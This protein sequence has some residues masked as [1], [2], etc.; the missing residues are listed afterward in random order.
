[1][2]CGGMMEKMKNGEM[3]CGAMMEKMKGKMGNMDMKGGKNGGMGGMD[4]KK[5]GEMSCGS[6]ID[7][8]KAA[9]E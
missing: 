2:S 9:G 4:M 1:M 8:A 3:S 7:P 5:G 6:K